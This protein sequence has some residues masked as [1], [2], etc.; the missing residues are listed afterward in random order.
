MHGM[1]VHHIITLQHYIILL[2]TGVEK[3]TVNQSN[4]HVPG[5]GLNLDCS[6]KSRAILHVANHEA[7]T[8]PKCSKFS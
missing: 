8:P 6:L 7:K 2:W 1:L 4:V 3:G 5:Y